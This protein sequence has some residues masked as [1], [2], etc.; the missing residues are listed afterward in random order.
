[1]KKRLLILIFAM[2]LIF[3]LTVPAFASEEEAA[4]TAAT[5]TTVASATGI[6]VL[7][8]SVLM[9]FIT[10][11]KWFKSAL[12]SIVNAFNTVF[13][14]G[15]NVKSL[16][17]AVEEILTSFADTKQE[18]EKLFCE[19]SEQTTSQAKS[20]EQFQQAFALLCLYANNIN[21]YIKNEIF[22]LIKGEIP[23]KDTIE[24]TAAQ[25][26]EF[27]NSIM[28]TETKEGTPHLDTITEE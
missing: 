26:E 28:K 19:L 16:P 6:G 11:L 14:K 23:F 5:I 13:G 3:A 10:K 9:F 8:L 22:R 12:H 27:A 25:I 1:M 4:T 15:A 17:I 18:F 21:P 2:C 20:Y 7:L 24:A